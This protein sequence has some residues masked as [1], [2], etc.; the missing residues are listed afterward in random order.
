MRSFNLFAIA[1][2]LAGIRPDDPAVRTVTT[3]DF[4]PALPQIGPDWRWS[5]SSDVAIR[6]DYR[7]SYRAHRREA[8]KRR[9]VRM[10]PRG[11]R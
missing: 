9:N 7:R 11:S 5:G 6:R 1:A 10:N 2:A 8:T 3:S 4:V